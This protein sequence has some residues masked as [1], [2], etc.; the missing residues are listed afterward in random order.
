MLGRAGPA[1]SLELKG[2]EALSGMFRSKSFLG[3]G[4][5]PRLLGTAPSPMGRGEVCLSGSAQGEGLR[6]G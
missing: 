6:W 3:G 5:P 4:L 2:R 1:F